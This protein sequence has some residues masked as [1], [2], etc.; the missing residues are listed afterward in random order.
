MISVVARMFS[1]WAA[2][3]AMVPVLGDVMSS[4]VSAFCRYFF[5]LLHTIN[6]T[7]YNISNALTRGLATRAEKRTY[8]ISLLPHIIS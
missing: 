6:P 7:Y 3:E 1:F 2:C 5:S 4:Q 8:R